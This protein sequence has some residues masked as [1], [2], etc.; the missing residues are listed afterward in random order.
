VTS[1]L[2]TTLLF[3]PTN[4][5]HPPLSPLCWQTGKNVNCV[6]FPSKFQTLLRHQQVS[7]SPIF[8]EQLFFLKKNIRPNADHKTL[9]KLSTGVDFINVLHAAFTLEDPKSTKNTVKLSFFF[10]FVLL[11]SVHVQAAHKMLVKLTTGR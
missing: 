3:L 8:Y 9:V 11:G 6:S 10:V 4:P 7:I 5:S 1:F 2:Y